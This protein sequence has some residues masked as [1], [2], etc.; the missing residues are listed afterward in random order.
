[1]KRV[2]AAFAVVVLATCIGPQPALA[3]TTAGIQGTVVDSSG[4]VVGGVTVTARNAGTGFQRQATTG[5]DGGYDLRLLPIGAYELIA[6]KTGFARFVHS[7]IDLHV[8]QIA[9]VR[10]DLV[11]KGMATEVNVS[12]QAPMLDLTTATLGKVVGE[13]DVLELPLNGRNFTQLGL[14]Q[15]GVVATTPELAMTG[16]GIEKHNPFQ[17]NGQRLQSNRFMIDG[18]DNYDLERGGYALLPPPD[19]L[20]EFKILTN[21][22]N[23][24]F[25]SA[26]AA[27]V[28]VAT[29]SGTNNFHGSVYD[30]LRNSA[31][32]SRGFFAAQK[33][34]LRQNQFGATFGGP[35]RRNRTFF[36]GYYDG[37]RRGQGQTMRTSV[38]TA[39]ERAGDFSQSAVKPVDPATGTAFPNDQIPTA[40]MDPIG[41]KFANMYPLPNGPQ[42]EFTSSPVGTDTQNNFGVR[43]DHEL[44]KNDVF[45]ARYLF[46]DESRFLP[47]GRFTLVPGWPVGE[48]QRAQSLMAHV[49][50]TFNPNLIAEVRI[51]YLRNR[52]LLIDPLKQGSRTD[53]GFQFP[54][55]SGSE[56]LPA[57]LLDGYTGE[58][59]E[60]E[61]PFLRK[62]NTYELRTDWSYVR[63]EH[64]MKF[65]FAYQRLEEGF[66][67]PE[68]TNGQYEYSGLIS[69]N[70]IADLLLGIPLVFLQ[71]GGQPDRLFRSGY[72]A[73]YLQDEYK[74]RSNLT[75]NLGMRY[76]VWTAYDELHNRMSKF[77]PGQQ[78]TVFADAPT[79]F[80][81]FGDKGVP[82]SM[83]GTPKGNVGPRF[84]FAWD[85]F[86]RGKT[87]IRGGAGISYDT[88]TGNSVLQEFLAPPYFSLAVRVLPPS[89]ANPYAGEINPFSPGAPR[90]Q[91][92]L[93]WATL[94]NRQQP[95]SQQWN[96]GVQQQLGKSYL[97]EAAY[98]GNHGLHLLWSQDY[99]PARF[100]PGQSSVGNT[101]DR[102]LYPGIGAIKYAATAASSFYHALDLSFERRFSEKLTFLASYTFSKTIDFVSIDNSASAAEPSFPP[103]PFN[104]NLERG[105]SQLDT[106]NL[107]VLSGTYQLPGLADRSSWLRHVLGNW[108]SNIIFTARSGHPFTVTDPNDI[109]LNGQSPQRPDLIGDPNN[110]PK[111]VNEWFNTSAFKRLDPVA[112][113]GQI[114]TEGRNVV[115]GPG[116]VN[117][118][119]S[120]AKNIPFAE[121][122]S[123]QFRAEFFNTLNHPNFQIPVNDISSPDFGKIQNAYD[124]RIIQFGL[125]IYF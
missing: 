58:G 117:L 16:G 1:M 103:Y 39:L 79:G 19:A 14:L 22:Y 33:E 85:P 82:K 12:G 104:L 5:A 28:D 54:N 123:V 102:R 88:I 101:D 6:E 121:K 76:D 13:K 80:V 51:G 20:A 70:A 57:I 120:L 75:L 11:V 124:P 47:F 59:P 99:N 119:F 35:I 36:F 44:S 105:L 65:G 24:E 60:I 2:F 74:V 83:V 46:G 32:D 97:V 113:A 94:T 115:I 96:F 90:F 3:Q 21:S 61:G 30:F 45:T 43:F 27:I 55:T 8:N 50:H 72:Y 38:P 84:G 93:L 4:A 29:R 109:A 10:I 15:P 112:N 98:V 89:V 100:I 106:R 87:S 91:P 52:V 53:F 40:I 56:L 7:G 92:P 66:T 110:G 116:F 78:S 26:S 25:G 42:N 111:T 68:I 107:F 71:G 48:G 118:D 9:I 77:V 86:S 62:D 49:S 37:L 73:A 95:S 64:H 31:L 34:V 63:G 41:V 125:K 81:F 18:A 67:L 108:Q 23:A 17:V 69:G 114:G 122:R